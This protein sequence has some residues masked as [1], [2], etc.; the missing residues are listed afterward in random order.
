MMRRL[1]YTTA[2]LALALATPVLQ[3]QRGEPVRVELTTVEER[4]LARTITVPGELSPYLTVDIHARVSGF[5][6]SVRVDRG[7]RVAK[8]DLLATMTAPEL[9]AQRL[10][11]E[12]RLPA[13]EAEY[14]EAEAQLAAAENTHSR[15]ED[16]SKTPGAVAANDVVLAAKTV[17]AARARLESIG[18]SR[19]AA[20]AHVRSIQALEAFLNITAPFAGIVTERQAHPGA[21]A[22]PEGSRAMPLFRL[23]QIDRLRLVAAV[24]EAQA[25]TIVVG[26]RAS[27]TVPAWPGETFTGVIARPA[28]SVDP[29][30]RTMPVE[31]DVANPQMRLAPGMYAEVAWPIRRT[32]AS[33]FVP[34]SAIKATTERIFVIR[35][36]QGVAEWVDVRRGMADGN[37]IEVLGDLKGGDTIVLRATD[38]IRPGTPVAARQGPPS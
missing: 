38:E 26:G 28:R 6:D 17:E 13:F 19:A 35:V 12:A 32:R 1:P 34:P 14:R 29:K 23:E 9:E 15:L 18:K 11:A 20:E 36:N 21:L 5:V 10:E 27:F 30:T 37:L 22:G 4:P 2:W 16:A 8:G 24:P 3:G 25:G 33:L 31:L 7:S